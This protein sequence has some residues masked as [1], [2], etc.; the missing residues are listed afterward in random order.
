MIETTDSVRIRRVAGAQ[1]T[2]LQ[3]QAT[4]YVRESTI[5]LALTTGEDP[6]TTARPATGVT[7][8]RVETFIR[9]FTALNGRRSQ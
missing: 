5:A 4:A 7:A 1:I 3:T 9:C 8:A 6:T 2:A